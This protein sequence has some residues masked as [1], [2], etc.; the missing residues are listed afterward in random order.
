MTSISQISI[1]G[2]GWLGL[3]LA[4]F[5]ISKNYRVKGSTTN[6]KKLTVLSNKKIKPYEITLSEDR[7]TGDLKG[8]LE[9]STVLIL[10]IPP[11]LKKTPKKN[12]VKEIALLLN[13]L[14]ETSITHL[15]YISS[16]S[17]FEDTTNFPVIENDSL[18]NSQSHSGRQLMAIETLLKSK[19]GL[20]VT[21][22]RFAGLFDD[23]RHPGYFLS[24]KD[25]LPN[26]KAPINLIHK[27]DCIA[28]IYE[29]LSLNLWT[30]TLNA[31]YPYH[32]TKND[33]Y[34]DFCKKK[35]IALPRFNAQIPAKGKVISCS[36]SKDVLPYR[37]RYKP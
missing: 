5:L 31:S 27:M 1:L 11:G 20:E 8:F 22:L 18:P 23:H 29:I 14:N 13:A 6:P 21:I 9:H 19:E 7:I 17:V 10:N 3:P 35:Q 4:E 33:Y 26:G 30:I 28:I 37:L 25:K 32:P 34:T 12:H 2:C 36:Q 15:L 24:G 16:T